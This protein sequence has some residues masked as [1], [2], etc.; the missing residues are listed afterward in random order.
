LWDNKCMGS[1]LLSNNETLQLFN[2]Y[3]QSGTYGKRA[4]PA[5][6]IGSDV[7]KAHEQWTHEFTLDKR[8]QEQRSLVVLLENHGGSV[9]HFGRVCVRTVKRIPN[10][11]AGRCCDQTTMD[12][13]SKRNRGNNRRGRHQSKRSRT[14]VGI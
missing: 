5:D 6:Q 12:S 1:V 14:C 11:M 8:S 4:N 3:H 7:N 13:A 2:K 10:Q 9:V